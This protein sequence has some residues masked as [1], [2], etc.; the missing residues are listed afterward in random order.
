MCGDF[1]IECGWLMINDWV[2]DVIEVDSI[3]EDVFY[4]VGELF[5]LGFFVY[6]VFVLMFDVEFWSVGLFDFFCEFL[7]GVIVK[8]GIWR[9]VVFVMI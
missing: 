9:E 3:E 5:L 6:E 4:W 2:L 1:W 7:D 8:V